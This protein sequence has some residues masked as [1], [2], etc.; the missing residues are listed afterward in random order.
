MSEI[1][2]LIKTINEMT[3]GFK[4]G[5]KVTTIEG[6]LGSVVDIDKVAGTYI[7][8]VN[9]IKIDYFD[10]ELTPY[11]DVKRLWAKISYDGNWINSFALEKFIGNL[12]PNNY[13]INKFSLEIEEE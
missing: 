8:E 5:D 9:G 2:D 4:I 13:D 10:T 3:S 7:V 11:K 1:H 12:I 6:K